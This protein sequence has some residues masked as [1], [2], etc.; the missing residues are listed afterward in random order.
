[1]L[2]GVALAMVLLAG[3]GPGGP[4]STRLRE[5]VVRP[6][7]G[8][9]LFLCDGFQPDL[10]EQGCREGWLP[11]IQKRFVEGG[12]RVEN[13]V[14]IIPPITYAAIASIVTGALPPDHRITGNRWFDP[15]ERLFRDYVTIRYYRAVNE[16]FAVPTLYERLDP[17]A[18]TSI[19]A[20]HMRGVTDNI[21][22]W[23]ESGVRWFFGIYTGVDKL[24][25]TTVE[26]VAGRANARGLW[27]TALMCYFPGLDSVGHAHGV[28]SPEYRRA[29]E[30]MDHQVGRVCDW[31][32]REGL[33]ETTYMVL[34]ADHGMLDVSEFVDLL[35]LLRDGWGREATDAIVQD[36]SFE[37]RCRFYDRFDSVVAHQD[38]R[39]ASLY[40][41]GTGGWDTVPEPA[42][43]E[44]VLTNP[45]V[46]QQL[47]SLPGVDLVMYLTG[48]NEACLRSARGTARITMRDRA[49]GPEYRYE[50]MTADVLG[51]T[52][53]ADLAA[54]VAAGFHHAPAWLAATASAE[55]PNLVPQVVPLLHEPRAGQVIVCAAPGYSFTREAGGHGGVRRAEVR[56]PL[57]FAGPGIEPGSVI[58]YA[59]TVDIV[60]TVLALLGTD[61]PRDRYLAGVPRLDGA[62]A[63]AV[64]ART[65][66]EEMSSGGK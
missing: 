44:H 36:G 42:V 37:Q 22:N 64:R 16:D 13:A 41:A 3:C 39:K 34:V 66:E 48:E 35:A 65:P 45:P 2:A 50:P 63:R 23:A 20:A 56:V 14:T 30:H 53:D 59:Q 12:M 27:P 29:A 9:V 7:P 11:N 26:R 33:L 10:L 31:L 6:E 24:T 38:G 5:T 1:M 19:Q 18:S 55:F 51:Y 54:F 61:A 58:P 62:W 40:F 60:P 52:E 15:E 43:V 21:A 17:A 46:E 28:S 25:A 49:D 47:W 57:L 4:L 8:V 32:D